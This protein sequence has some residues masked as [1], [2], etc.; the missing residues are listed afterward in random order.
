MET[1]KSKGILL[2]PRTEL[3]LLLFANVVAFVHHSNTVEIAWI[4]TLCLIL[5]VC[6]CPGS[7]LKW[8]IAYGVLL[9]LQHYVLPHAPKIIA[10]MFALSFTYARKI[11]PCMI[12]GTLILKKTSVRCLLLAFRKWHVPQGLII[13]LAVTIRYFPAMKEELGYIRDAMKFRQVRGAQ[14]LECMVVPLMIS[15]TATAEELSAAAITRG[16]ENPAPKTS[17]KKLSFSVADIICLAV[18]IGFIAA[19]FL[20]R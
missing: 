14:K 19:A 6:G 12:T 17:M 4:L 16:I 3:L 11:F 7:A 5:A 8:V 10:T 18:G 20:V 2:D 13:P 9:C 15:A 1:V